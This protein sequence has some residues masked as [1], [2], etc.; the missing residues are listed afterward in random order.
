[1]TN[2]NVLRRF[3]VLFSF[4]VTLFACCVPSGIAQAPAKLIVSNANIF[5]M[6]PDQRTPFRGYLVVG[7]DGR[8]VTVAAGATSGVVEGCGEVECGGAVG[9]AGVYFGA[10]S[11]VAECVPGV[12]FGS[13]AA[14][15][16]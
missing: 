9:D 7:Q 4:F 11:S 12:G 1:M 14:R 6:A 3:A 16:D 2:E 10:Q 5:S 13:D 15:V 8:L